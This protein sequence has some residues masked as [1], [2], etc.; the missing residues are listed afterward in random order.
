[1]SR[2]VSIVD[3]GVGNLLSVSRAV[4][5]AGGTP[6]LVRTPEE[7]AEAERLLLPGVGAFGHCMDVLRARDLIQPIRDFAASG[8]PF[9]GICVGMQVLL[10]EGEEF[11]LH[12][13]LGLIPGRVCRIPCIDAEGVPQKVPF[14][15]W[16]RLLRPRARLDWG[17]T[18]LDGLGDGEAW[19]YFTH[20]YAAFPENDAHRLAEADYFG[21]RLTAAI[22]R[23]NIT[24]CQ[25]H[26]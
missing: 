13:G 9:L 4:V 14:V 20:S 10:E 5:A 21:H 16:N 8:G 6:I 3:Y 18:V 25:F 24:G 23:D 17:G 22:I 19:V 26:T 11:G 12:Q 7:V 1:M 2:R 15:G